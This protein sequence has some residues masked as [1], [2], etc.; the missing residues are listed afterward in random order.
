MISV[1]S[2]LVGLTD[3]D[4]ARCCGVCTESQEDEQ[5]CLSVIQYYLTDYLKY[6]RYEYATKRDATERGMCRLLPSTF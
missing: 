4:N 3:G 2:G 6:H 5:K 1:I